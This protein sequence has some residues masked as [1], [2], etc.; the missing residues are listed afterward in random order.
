MIYHHIAK[1]DMND[2]PESP[3]AEMDEPVE[4]PETGEPV[5]PQEAAPDESEKALVS[6]VVQWCRETREFWAETRKKITEEIEFAAGRQW[7]TGAM[8]DA[9][10][11]NYVANFTRR[12]VNQKVAQT[13]AKNPRTVSRMRPQQAYVLWDGQQDSLLAAQMAKR[14]PLLQQAALVQQDPAAIKALGQAEAILADYE[15][16]MS[17][18]QMLKR[19]GRT[20]ELVYDHQCDQQQPGFKVQMKALVRRALTARVGWVKLCYRREGDT[21]ETDSALGVTTPDLMKNIAQK[22]NAIASG[23]ALDEP[24][25]KQEVAL[26]LQSL[27]VGA[28]NGDEKLVDEGLVFDFPKATSILVD[29]NCTSLKT[30]ANCE[31]IAQEYLLTPEEVER[32]YGVDVKGDSLPYAKNGEAFEQDAE[33]KWPETARVCV[34]EVYDKCAQLK[35]VVCD[36][37]DAFLEAPD[38]PRPCISRFWPIF[39]LVFNEIEIEENCPDKDVT[40]YPPSDVRVLMPMQEEFNRSRQALREHRIQNRPLYAASP[41]LTEKDRKTLAAGHP[42]GYVVSLEGL[43]A[44]GDVN[45]ALQQV[46]KQAI[47]PAVY[48]TQHLE[49]DVLLSVGAQQANLGPT[50]GAT[51]TETSV[52]EGSRIQAGSSDLDDLDVLMCELARAGG[53]M[54]MQEMDAEKA[55]MIA[56]P[57]AAWPSTKTDIYNSELYLE[58]E[59][60]GSGRPNKA[61]EIANAQIMFPLLVQVPGVNPEWL[62]KQ[63]L[64]RLDEHVDL[65]E[66]FQRDLPTIMTMNAG[67]KADQVAAGMTPAG[68]PGAQQTQPGLQPPNANDPAARQAQQSPTTQ[69]MPAQFQNKTAA[70]AAQPA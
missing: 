39:G 14:D 26:M 34:W 7:P 54:L 31:R 60:S 8:M 25:L 45:R 27:Q 59:A 19:W 38:K 70:S 40:C 50:S 62:A 67:P 61:A 18:K 55:R 43:P 22:L 41:N 6:E 1:T 5:Q 44:D 53:E 32:R 12:L 23:E 48:Q 68:Q 4:T 37:Y 29:R 15:N 20:L 57:G 11:S 49:N 36:G 9:T 16:G 10:D 64:T 66:A 24:R 28:Q 47:D 51:A 69:G 52:A 17:R 35:Y 56:G 58:T 65:E 33:T 42:S 46:K 3:T 21:V 63:M 30:F 2:L 13:Y